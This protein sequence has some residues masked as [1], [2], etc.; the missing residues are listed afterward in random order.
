M[1]TQARALERIKRIAEAKCERMPTELFVNAES[2]A[3][4][5]GKLVAALASADIA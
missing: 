3:E 4:R 1:T 5:L 2:A